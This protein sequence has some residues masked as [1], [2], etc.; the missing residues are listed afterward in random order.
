MVCL[1]I[2]IHQEIT[3]YLVICEKTQSKY[4]IFVSM[5]VSCRRLEKDQVFTE[6]NLI[7]LCKNYAKGDI[8]P[9]LKKLMPWNLFPYLSKL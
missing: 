9:L 2:C 5:S 3:A 6:K 7:D 8:P 1:P 4:I